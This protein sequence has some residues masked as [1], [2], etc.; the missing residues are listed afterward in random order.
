MGALV[1]VLAL[2]V[3]LGSL[4]CAIMVLIKL[5]QEEGALKGI[6]GLICG[7][8]TFIWGWMNAD[9]LNIKNIMLIWTALIVVGIILQVVGGGLAAMSQ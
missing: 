3:G 2:V 9:R 7:L 1:G 4:V 5:F 6:L 8:Y